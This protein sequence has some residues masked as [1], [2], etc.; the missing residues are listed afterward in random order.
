MTYIDE[1]N[2]EYN[3]GICVIASKLSKGLEFDSVIIT[4]AS[5]E[6]YLKDN[7]LD[8]KLLYVA[9]TRAMHNLIVM[10]KNDLCEILK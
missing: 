6:K 7:Q 10:Y 1:N 3:S 4:D 2:Q 5:K 9:M 8:M